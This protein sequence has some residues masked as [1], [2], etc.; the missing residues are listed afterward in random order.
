LDKCTYEAQINDIIK[1][2]VEKI[3]KSRE[4]IEKELVG[5][6]VIAK[7][8]D[9][10]LTAS[11][12]NFENSLTNYDNLVINLLPESLQ[13]PKESHYLRILAIC[14]FVASLTDGYALELYKKLNG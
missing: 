6:N 1:I 2:S 14:G 11:N 4:V 12:R 5:Y 10:F 13:E 3:Y 8:L 7:L 9:V